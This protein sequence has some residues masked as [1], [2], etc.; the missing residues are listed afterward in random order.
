M[1]IEPISH[2]LLRFS[3]GDR[4]RKS[5]QLA[6]IS[7]QEM[8]DYLEVSR[9]TVSRWINDER[10]PN[11]SFVRLWALRT[12]VP[13]EWIETGSVNETTPSPEGDGVETGAP[14]QIRTGD[15][16]FTSY[17]AVRRLYAAA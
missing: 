14:S 3:Q 15:L 9:N 8:A 12:G 11:R 7:S 2:E 13:M 6:G 1:S 16:L 10:E 5:L 4:L 17:P